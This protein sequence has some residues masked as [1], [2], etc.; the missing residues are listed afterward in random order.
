MHDS[1]IAYIKKHSTTPLTEADIEAIKDVF[2]PKKIRKRQYFLQE[3]DVCKY[4]AFIVKER[5]GNTDDLIQSLE[6][7]GV[8]FEVFRAQRST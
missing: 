7:Q 2:I 3:G 1:L 4:A 6:R 8:P 5:C